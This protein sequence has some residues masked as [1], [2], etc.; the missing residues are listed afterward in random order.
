VMLIG[1]KQRS[2]QKIEKKRFTR[3]LCEHRYAQTPG[4]SLAE[5]ETKR[6]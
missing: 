2:Q 3:S 6:T 1:V 5:M 4:G